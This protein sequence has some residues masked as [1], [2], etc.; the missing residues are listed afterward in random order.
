MHTHISSTKEVSPLL[1][2]IVN[3]LHASKYPDKVVFGIRLALEEGLVNAI[4]HG[5]HYDPNKSVSVTYYVTQDQI[6]IEIEDEGEGFDPEQVPD[7]TLS[8]NLEKPNGRGLLLMRHYMDVVEYDNNRLT[9]LWN[10][11]ATV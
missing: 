10:A 8:E 2:K 9:L 3:L 7:S 6:A 1:D 4:K 11:M 5:N